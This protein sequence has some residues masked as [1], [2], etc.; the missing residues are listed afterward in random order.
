MVLAIITLALLGITV[1][2]FVIGSIWLSKYAFRLGTG[3][4]L[5][6]LLFPPYAFYFAFYKLEQETKDRPTALWMFG[7]V[8]SV[9]LVAIFW[10][11]LSTAARGD[12][13]AL[14]A[15]E[16]EATK[17]KKSASI[18]KAPAKEAEDEAPAAEEAGDDAPAES[19]DA[20][21]E[22]ESAEGDDAAAADGEEAAEKDSGDA[23]AENT[24]GATE[25]AAT[26]EAK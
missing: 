19:E 26:D 22:G 1:A 14:A 21:A 20:A 15:P 3:H 23:T 7:L 5:G 12:I 8:A 4:G 18:E 25:G 13:S 11:P 10:A 6:V 24:E 2:C 16:E 17:P 9:L